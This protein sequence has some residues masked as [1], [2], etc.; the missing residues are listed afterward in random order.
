MANNATF[1]AMDNV[2]DAGNEVVNRSGRLHGL[3]VHNDHTA[4][5]YLHL[6]D[7]VNANVDPTSD[8]GDIA[9]ISIAGDTSEWIPIT[10][11]FLVG[12]VITAS[13]TSAAA[14]ADATTVDVVVS[15][16]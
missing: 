14:G 8:V 12:L 3:W 1:I 15:Y 11:E 4:T 6:Y 10:A 2:G 16:N 7:E 5:Q 13:A 9:V